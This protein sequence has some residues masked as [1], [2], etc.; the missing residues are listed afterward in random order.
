M[1]LWYRVI[2]SNTAVSVH[3]RQETIPCQDSLLNATRFYIVS[4]ISCC[5]QKD[6]RQTKFLH[7]DNV[8]GLVLQPSMKGTFYDLK[9]QILNSYTAAVSYTEY[10]PF[11]FSICRLLKCRSKLY[12]IR[13]YLAHI[14]IH[15]SP[16]VHVLPVHF[17]FFLSKTMC[18]E[19]KMRL[20]TYIH[21]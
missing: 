1:H 4:N 9:E 5:Y 20:L 11:T 15:Y 17:L 19:K 18:Y 12:R 10:F 3:C 21:E 2:N 7:S 8:P 6:T 13:I 14:E 16:L